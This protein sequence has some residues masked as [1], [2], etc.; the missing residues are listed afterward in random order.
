MG[1]GGGETLAMYKT[2][3][4]GYV[5]LEQYGVS[6][7]DQ[8]FTLYNNQSTTARTTV[9]T[10]NSRLTWQY[11]ASGLGGSSNS[12]YAGYVAATGQYYVQLDSNGGGVETVVTTPEP[13]ALVMFAAGAL[14]LLA[15]A[16]RKWK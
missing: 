9:T 16:W 12:G 8:L 4:S 2:P 10:G 11:V 7:M 3:T 6:A 5:P 15:Y 14:G 1:T 13:C